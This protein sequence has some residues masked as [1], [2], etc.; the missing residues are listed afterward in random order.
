MIGAKAPLICFHSLFYISPYPTQNR[1]IIQSTSTTTQIISSSS[2]LSSSPSTPPILK[3][4]L[5]PLLLL[6][7]ALF[8]TA[9]TQ[10][11]WNLSYNVD[12]AVTATAST[13]KSKTAFDVLNLP[14]HYEYV[15]RR[16]ETVE[17]F[18]YWDA[19]SKLWKGDGL[20]EAKHIS[21]VSAALLVFF[22]GVWPHLKLGAVGFCWFWK[23]RHSL[24]DNKN[25]NAISN[26]NNNS[27]GNNSKKKSSLCSGY[28]RH[29][30]TTNRS[31]VL[32]ILSV[33][34]KWSLAD[35]LVVCILIA[36]LH[37]DWNVDVDAVRTGVEEKLG[38]ILSFV[39]NVSFIYML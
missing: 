37:L 26:N 20:N 34:G 25:N 1:P 19:I 33:F 8:L 17:V 4:I 29:Q 2:S 11:M 10:P 24:D 23:F 28:H 22:S 36:V 7:H 14:H 35:V 5:P 6:N 13:F 30:S 12:I 15:Q 3:Y 27:N 18:T 21:K 38:T 9:Q 31:P 16:N 39:Q 32:R